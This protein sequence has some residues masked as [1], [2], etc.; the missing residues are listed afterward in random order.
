MPRPP[1]LT[2]EQRAEINLRRA[3][4][5]TFRSIA[6]LFGV[7]ESTVRGNVSPQIPQVQQTA[8]KIAD[9][10]EALAA[11]P[12]A[13]QQTALSLADKLR[14]ISVSLAEAACIGAATAHTLQ[15]HASKEA[16]KIE[17]AEPEQ[18][19]NHLRTVAA[20]TKVANEA[21]HIGLNLL[22]ANRERGRTA[23]DDAPLVPQGAPVPIFNISLASGE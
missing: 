16:A 15:Q 18:A 17:Q 12:P 21:S 22:A 11:L 3:S 1:K 7:D 13:H 20:L 2:P 23:G 5:E 19:G 8:Q 14:S 9:A 10:R 6:K 4:G